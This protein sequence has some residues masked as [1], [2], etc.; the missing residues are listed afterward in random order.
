MASR[1]DALTTLSLPPRVS[2]PPLR[3]TLVGSEQ[4]NISMPRAIHSTRVFRRPHAHQV[5]RLVGGEGLAHQRHNAVHIRL[6]LAHAQPANGVSI[7][8]QGRDGGGGLKA[9]IG[10]YAALD[11]AEKVLVGTAVALPASGGPAM[12]A[13]HRLPHPRLVGVV[14]SALVPAP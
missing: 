8:V 5:A 6:G 3:A 12:G 11:Y 13:L 4:S 1:K 7:K 2:M 9:H 10:R 14:G